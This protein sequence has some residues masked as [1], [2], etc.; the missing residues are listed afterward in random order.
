M[1]S[2]A[3]IA[4]SASV[5]GDVWALDFEKDRV[6]YLPKG[7]ASKAKFF[8]KSTG[9]KPNKDSPCKLSGPFHL[10]IDQQDRIWDYQCNR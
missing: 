2:F 3:S 7:D 4:R 5:K 9:G 8:C 6:V 1:F 10:A